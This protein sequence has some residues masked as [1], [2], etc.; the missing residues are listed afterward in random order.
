MVSISSQNRV[1]LWHL[2]L[3]H[4]SLKT[5]EKFIPL[6]AGHENMQA[7]ASVSCEACVLET[8]GGLPRKSIAQNQKLESAPLKKTHSNLV[9]PLTY[10]F[11]EKPKHF[12]TL[13]ILSTGN[14]VLKF[15]DRRS[16]AENAV[17]DTIINFYNEF[18][19]RKG[20]LEKTYCIYVRRLRTDG[21]GANAISS[22]SNWLRSN[23]ILHEGTTAYS[24]ESNRS[25][26]R[27]NRLFLDSA[28]A[29]LYN[30]LNSDQKL[31]VE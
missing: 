2:W 25:A 17:E 7:G 16:K 31:W 18:N 29:I 26:G 12:G 24:P 4:C 30:S 19:C 5:L 15:L 27:L 20:K 6:T 13:L 9:S 8:F 21:G 3:G 10:E 1:Q 11:M 23:G 28:W 22:V 14:S